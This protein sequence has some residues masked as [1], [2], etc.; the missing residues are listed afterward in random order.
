MIR[1]SVSNSAVRSK[2]EVTTENLNL[3]IILSTVSTVHNFPI[4]T[5]CLLHRYSLSNVFAE[6]WGVLLTDGAHGTKN[7]GVVQTTVKPQ[8]FFASVHNHHHGK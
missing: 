8:P 2:D 1:Y 3:S 5:P 6:G 7:D 4:I